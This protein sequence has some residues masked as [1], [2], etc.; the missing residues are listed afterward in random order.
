MIE[1]K[2]IK[3]EN[4][5]REKLVVDLGN[6]LFRDRDKNKNLRIENIKKIYDS[7][8]KA[9]YEPYL[10]LD[11]SLRHIMDHEEDYEDLLEE[12]I[13]LQAPAGRKAD[14]FF[15]KIA[16]VFKCKFLTNDLCKKY[17]DEYGKEWIKEHR[18]TFMFIDGELFIE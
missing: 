18:M 13:V 6:I 11:A 16:K 17:Y 12:K 8:V 5:I 15:L 1:N 10:I 9:N 14:P 2:R 7:I 4:I 3:S